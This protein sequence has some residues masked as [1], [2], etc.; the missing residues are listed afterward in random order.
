MLFH[1]PLN[2]KNP[3]LAEHYTV[4]KTHDAYLLH[5]LQICLSLLKTFYTHLIASSYYYQ[6]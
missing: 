3:L 4:E 1:K 2:L 6:T 5:T